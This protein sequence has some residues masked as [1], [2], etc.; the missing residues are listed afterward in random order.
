MKP[1]LQFFSHCSSH[2]L[3][4][5]HELIYRHH[6]AG[7]SLLSR[8]LLYNECGVY[9]CWFSKAFVLDLA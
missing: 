9:P 3:G 1:M 4:M 6:T 2:I 8:E 5:R 7:I